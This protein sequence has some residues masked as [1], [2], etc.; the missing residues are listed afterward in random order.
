MKKKMVVLIGLIGIA[1]GIAAQEILEQGSFPKPTTTFHTT[2]TSSE[3]QHLFSCLSDVV[4]F[5]AN[6]PTP[7]VKFVSFNVM[8]N[9]EV[10]VTVVAN[11]PPNS[12]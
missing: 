7:S 8:T 10:R 1:F 3:A 12:R 9:G 5:P 2:L 4:Q 6:M 11:Q